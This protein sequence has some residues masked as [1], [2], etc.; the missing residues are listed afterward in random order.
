MNAYALEAEHNV[1]T[2][3][4]WWTVADVK[5]ADNGLG[6]GDGGGDDKFEE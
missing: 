6:G 1:S 4:R 3:H 2:S 5:C